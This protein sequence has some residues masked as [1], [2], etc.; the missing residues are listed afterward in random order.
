MA[1][2][3]TSIPARSPVTLQAVTAESVCEITALEVSPAQR[4]F[5]SPNA[6]SIAEAYFEKGAWF[7]ALCAGETPVGFVM[8][9]DPT[10]PGACLK[11][12]D[13]ENDLVLWRFMIAHGHQG[14]GYGRQALDLVRAHARS[15]PGI[16][17]L[18]ATYVP[19]PGGPEGFYL[20]YG[21][22]KT[23]R[24]RNHDREIEISIVP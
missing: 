10:L 22:S 14:R 6:V 16:V 15:R 3:K 9:F 8:L 5:V 1:P 19:G 17:R 18:T 11:D 4:G 12:D 21:F 20:K 7:R 24:L 23:G 13:I 2:E